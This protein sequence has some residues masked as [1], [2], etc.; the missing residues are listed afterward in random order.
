MEDASIRTPIKSLNF[1]INT[2]YEPLAHAKV[3]M[4]GLEAM[5][6]SLCKCNEENAQV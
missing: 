3:F 2:K 1:S 6:T 4:Q 5:A